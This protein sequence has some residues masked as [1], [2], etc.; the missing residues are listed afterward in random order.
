MK[1]KR[2]VLVEFPYPSG[3]G[4]HM[5]HAF[6]FTGGDVYARTMRMQ[7]YDVLF[8]IGWDSFGLPTENYAIRTGRNPQEVT[9][10]NTTLFE[11]QMRAMEF[12]F[13]YD[14]M[15]DTSDPHF[16]RF[17]QWIF[18]K[19]YEHG[20]AYKTQMPINWCPSCKVGLA[21]EEVIDGACER[22]G[23]GT[24][25]RNISQW[26]V[27]ITEYAD[28][29]IEGLQ[30]TDFPDSVRAAQI[31]WIGRS[32]GATIEFE[33]P[34]G[35]IEVFTTRPDTLFG[36]VAVVV[37]PEHEIVERVLGTPSDVDSRA[38]DH[39]AATVREY[40]VS[41]A[42][43]SER[44]RTTD[45]QG[46][47]GVP[48]GIDAVHP[49]T[50]HPIPVWVADFVIGGYGTGAVM[51]VP[52]HDQRDHDFAVAHNLPIIPVIR[53]PSDWDYSVAA[54]EGKEGVAVDSEPWDGLAADAAI[55]A[56]IDWLEATDCGVRSISYHLR[57]WIFSRQH[58]WG[59]PIP[60]VYCERC[61]WVPVPEEEL[62][63]RLPDVERYEPT[64]SGESPLAS[65]EWWVATTCPNCGGTARRETDTM[66]NW[67]GS[68]WYFLRYCDPHN[69][70]VIADM[71]RL[72][73]Y[74]PVDVYI[75]GDE[76]NTLHLLYS[77]FIYLFL[78]DL[79]VVPK[80]VVE[81]YR[82]RWSHGVILGTDGRRMSKSRGN[83]LA[84]DEYVEKYGSDALRTY[85]MFMGPFDATL[86]WNDQALRGVTRFLE[87]FRS[88][89]RDIAEAP[90]TAGANGHT[91]APRAGRS[92]DVA[93]HCAIARVTEDIES[94]RFN[95]AVATLMET[96]NELREVL[97]IGGRIN[98]KS[99]ESFISLLAPIAPSAAESAWNAIGA[100]GSVHE[101][102]WPT[103][104]ERLLERSRVTI[105]VQVDGRLRGTIEVDRASSQEEVVLRARE[106]GTV[107]RH[108]ENQTVH[109]VVY[110]PGKMVN[111]VRAGA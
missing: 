41:A 28:R 42:A 60:M 73:H 13:E 67:A 14:R 27:K 98:R 2:Y 110:V 9:R 76:H 20:L 103:A 11:T 31:N 100:S 91:D 30:K 93:I 61:G 89:V 35:R 88:L 56:A 48:L 106:A 71:E 33:T 99:A 4:L 5:G 12:S 94:F 64:D 69:P 16:Y 26:V 7:G 102:P 107:T 8:P 57:D 87:R 1:E 90:P 18:L 109:R 85:L 65:V 62:P 25:R 77:R 45:S 78:H 72:R 44:E 40:V 92:A 80:E 50:G 51:A 111:F 54:Y 55:S 29:L 74:L 22:C 95:T 70:T 38:P 86:Q 3:V 32:E 58:Y 63:I 82:V 68:D 21:N 37:A 52:A 105:A 104:D 34:Y 84:P 79:G 17:T 19:L 81:P 97:R 66:P 53:P 23:A 10:E 101:Q 46:K 83:G 49:A 75:G 6:T 47:T 108:L 39:P 59:E 24:T 96:T 43:K 15:V 36:A